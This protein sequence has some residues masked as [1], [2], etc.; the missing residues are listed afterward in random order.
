MG[1]APPFHNR[2]LLGLVL[3]RVLDVVAAAVGPL[4]V[5]RCPQD[6][7][8]ALSTPLE[9]SACI[10]IVRADLGYPES[11]GERAGESDRGIE[12]TDEAKM[13]SDRLNDT[14][15]SSAL[16]LLL[17]HGTVRWQ[18]VSI[19]DFPSKETLS[20]RPLSALGILATIAL[21]LGRNS[22]LG[23]TVPST[24]RQTSS[25]LMPSGSMVPSHRDSK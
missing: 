16:I 17:D 13:R 14:A 23:E 18:S 4:G 25:S 21:I 19:A 6:E 1:R 20:E 9:R 10:L 7:R 3:P 22:D 8:W 5:V 2:S 15:G 24:P 12:H 11:R